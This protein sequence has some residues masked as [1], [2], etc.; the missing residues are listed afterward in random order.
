[1]IKVELTNEEYNMIYSYVRSCY[2]RTKRMIDDDSYHKYCIEE[3][4]V[5]HLMF[6]EDLRKKLENI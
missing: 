1:M 2:I 5:G 4:L 6:L 3:E